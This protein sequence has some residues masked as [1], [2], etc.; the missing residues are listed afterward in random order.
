VIASDVQGAA[1]NWGQDDQ[2]MLRKT[3][4]AEMKKYVGEGQFPAGSM[5]P[6]V[7]AVMQFTGSHRQPGRHLSAIRYRK[8]DRRRGRH[9]NY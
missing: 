5:G 2:K 7:D 8:S 3:A 4:L 6:K 1:I 9:R